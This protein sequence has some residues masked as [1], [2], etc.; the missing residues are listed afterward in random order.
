M[1]VYLP[2]IPSWTLGY[3]TYTFSDNQI[4]MWSKLSRYLF[5]F[6][7]G[8]LDL[9]K[10]PST[11]ITE[12]VWDREAIV[13]SRPNRFLMIADIIEEDGSITEGEKVHVHDPGRLK[14]V[15]FPGNLVRVKK[16]TK[17]GRTTSWDLVSG[18]VD[19]KWILIN[20]SYHRKIS[21]EVLRDPDLS[22]YNGITSIEPE[23]R[24]GK[25]RIDFRLSLDDGSYCFVEVKGCTLS[26]NGA[27]LFPDA[28][29]SRGTRH[30]RE[31]IELKKLGHRASLM[32]L[33]LSPGS[34]S[35]SPNDATDP[36]FARAFWDAIDTGIEVYPISFHLDE[37]KLILDGVVPI[38]R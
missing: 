18:M 33:V 4:A 10:R 21:E 28:P 17:P 34:D 19:G 9:W 1:E 20:S 15:I 36:D 7:I 38:S 24:I 32:I 37:S 35:F 6:E 3:V 2:F 13:I 25:S 22:P 16:A 26:V 14:E 12:I 11:M 29:T 8:M 30:I 27:A 5:I 31:L 23:F